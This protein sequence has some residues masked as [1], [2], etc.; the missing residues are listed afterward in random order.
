EAVDVLE[1]ERRGEQP[2]LPLRPEEGQG[3]GVGEPALEPAGQHLVAGAEARGVDHLVREEAGAFVAEAL[4]E[5]RWR[6]ARDVGPRGARGHTP[7]LASRQ[8]EGAQPAALRP[9]PRR[10]DHTGSSS[11]VATTTGASRQAP[12]ASKPN[13]SSRWRKSRSRPRTPSRR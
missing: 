1:P 4:V 10:Y 11:V 7:A 8:R 5:R 9:R 12:R 13:R 2:A 3:P 6:Q